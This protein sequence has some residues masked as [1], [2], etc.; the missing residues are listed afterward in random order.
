MLAWIKDILL[1]YIIANG[2]GKDSD[3]WSLLILDPAP[4]HKHTRVKKFLKKN[5]L[6]SAMMPTN[7]TYKFQM[8]D[9]VVGKP[10]KDAMCDKWATLDAKKSERSYG[11][12]EQLQTSVAV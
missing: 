5:K 9:V 1:P 12:W 3:Q 6:M 11:S 2:G 4:A 8:I 10:F 7:T